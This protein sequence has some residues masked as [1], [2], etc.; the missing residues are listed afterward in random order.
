MQP[1]AVYFLDALPVT[2]T[3]KIEK[4]KL[5]QMALAQA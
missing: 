5:K 4:Y 2:P 3:S 1:E